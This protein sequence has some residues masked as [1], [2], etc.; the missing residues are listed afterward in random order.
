MRSTSWRLNG[1]PGPA[2]RSGRRRPPSTPD[3]A[4]VEAIAVDVDEEELQ[5]RRGRRGEGAVPDRGGLATAAAD[6]VGDAA[7]WVGALV[8]VV[9]AGEDEVDVVAGEDRL[10]SSAGADA[11]SRAGPTSTA[12]GAGR[13]SSTG[14]SSWP[15]C[16]R[17]TPTA[18]DDSGP[19][20][21]WH[22]GVEVEEVDRPVR[23]RVVAARRAEQP[24]LGLDLLQA[25]VA[26]AQGGV[27]VADGELE[28]DAGIEQRPHR[29]ARTRRRSGRRSCRS[30]RCRP[31]ARRDRTGRS[32]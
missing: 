9:V 29:P 16:R 18:R 22:A 28:P 30:S 15:G 2:A 20:T 7:L 32:R 5:D 13:R 4:A 26:V 8:V 11:S 31:G 14:S 3:A 27:V 12:G 19:K 23:G 25:L 21:P 1:P 17:A 24:Q 10:E 6:H